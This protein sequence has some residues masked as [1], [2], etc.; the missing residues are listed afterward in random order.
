LP[1]RGLLAVSIGLS[2]LA[3]QLARRPVIDPI[4]LGR[5]HERRGRATARCS[6]TTA[7][8]GRR[9]AGVLRSLIGEPSSSPATQPFLAIPGV[10]AV[11]DSRVAGAAVGI[12]GLGLGLGTAAC[13]VLGGIGMAASL[14]AFAAWART[15]IVRWGELIRPLF[16]TPAREGTP[17]D[18]LV[19]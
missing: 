2:F 12:A 18:R 17:V 6:S 5:P 11:V 13:L 16:R 9:Q 15:Q 14:V 7:P 19:D 10:I 8:G 3:T 4:A 1:K